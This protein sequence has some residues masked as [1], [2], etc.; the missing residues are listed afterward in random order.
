MSNPH[1]DLTLTGIGSMPGTDPAGT[2][3]LILDY[4]PDMPFWPQL[5]DLGPM[6]DMVVQQSAGLPG[7]AIRQDGRGLE[8]SRA[9]LE[10]ELT[11]FY[12]RYLAEDVEAFS[13]GPDR[14]KGL[15]E[16]LALIKRNG[17]HKTGRFIKGQSA[18]PFT[19]ASSIKDSDGRALLYDQELMEALIKGLSIKLLWQVRTLEKTARRAIVFLDEPVL[20]GVGSAFSPM[21]RDQVTD[22]LA[23]IISYLKKRSDALVGIHCCANTDWSMIFR[24][25][26]D[27]VSFDAFG[28]MESFLLYREAI[29]EFLNS[30]GTI[31]WGIVP[32]TETDGLET[33]ESLSQALEQAFSRVSG[34]G[35]D[36]QTLRQR[37]ILTP[38]CGAGTLAPDAAAK[39]IRMLSAIK[40]LME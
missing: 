1:F 27:I 2:C 22:A 39:S 12:D 4:L 18:G 9:C 29:V 20:A 5:A 24:A 25:N 37:S 10:A 17:D 14:A 26:P 13:L 32:T 3:R 7:L 31:A 21:D 16:L 36:P 28:Y 34:W 23:E 35:I 30:G 40:R 33:A 8:V 11:W 15:Y 6:E 38:S 19:M